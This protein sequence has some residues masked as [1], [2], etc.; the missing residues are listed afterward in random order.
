MG[1]IALA[2][3]AGAVAAG[4]SPGSSPQPDCQPGAPPWCSA[5][6][7]QS[8]AGA[9]LA[10]RTPTADQYIVQLAAPPVAAYKG[11]AKG[12]AATAPASAG[13]KVDTRSAAARAW[14]RELDDRQ[15]S[16]LAAAAP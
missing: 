13:A 2:T 10:A 14:S 11:G 1:A 8:P 15:A 9:R 3:P 5:H 16:V 4:S 12:F 7:A 6:A